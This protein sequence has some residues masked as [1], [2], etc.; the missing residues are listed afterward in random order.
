M[1]AEDAKL[2]GELTLLAEA[3]DIEVTDVD[4]RGD[5][6]IVR[7]MR[8]GPE[9]VGTIIN[10]VDR[11][12]AAVLRNIDR[13]GTLISDAYGDRFVI[14]ASVAKDRLQDARDETSFEIRNSW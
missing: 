11:R 1:A 10:P 4:V 3:V 6:K 9:A 2:R 8:N 12:A 5:D 14:T 13:W 7:V